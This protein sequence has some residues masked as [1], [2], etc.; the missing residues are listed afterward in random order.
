ERDALVNRH[1]VADLRRLADHHT[2]AVIDESAPADLRP[3]MGLDPGEEPAKVADE[4]RQRG[5]LAL[6]QPMRQP[7]DENRVKT[8]IRN[9]LFPR[10]PRR[11]IA[12]EDCLD[13]FFKRLPHDRTPGALEWW[14]IGVLG[15]CSKPSTPSL[16]Y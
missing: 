14:R 3:R 15:Q 13:I 7:V 9:R 5:E 4:A 16:R 8:R 12:L 11:R 6:P 10:R 1:V 2:H